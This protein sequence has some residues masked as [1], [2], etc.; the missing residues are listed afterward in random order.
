[1]KSFAH[2]IMDREGLH[3]RSCVIIVHEASK[4]DSE[5]IVTFH[6]FE[7]DAK[8]MA[9]LLALKAVRGDT[10]VVSCEGPDEVEAASALE[11]I[12]RMSI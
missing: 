10:L 12:M 4:W 2:V 8:R 6:E 3:A 1:M 9:P 11:A 7:A 5:V